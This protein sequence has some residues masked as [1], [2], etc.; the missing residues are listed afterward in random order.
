MSA[1]DLPVALSFHALRFAL[2]PTEKNFV[3][4]ALERARWLGGV[5]VVWNPEGEFK[6]DMTLHL[7]VGL[8]QDEAAACDAVRAVADWLPGFAGAEQHWSVALRPYLSRGEVN[9]HDGLAGGLMCRAST[10]RPE[11]GQPIV[12]VTSFGNIESR[13]GFRAFGR[14][15][16]QVRQSMRRSASVLAEFQLNALSATGSDPCTVA[17]WRNEAEALDWSYR[18]ETH[19]SAIDWFHTE[20]VVGRISFNRLL[21]VVTSGEP[22][23]APPV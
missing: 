16:Y 3:I 15:V 21:P 5:D 10:E 14:S 8:W 12:T 18:Q 20:Q 4:T 7:Y 1:I 19:R 23:T 13:S 17:L 22:W 6:P 2:P 9:W 11:P